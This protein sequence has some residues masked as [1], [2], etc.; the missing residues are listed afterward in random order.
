MPSF[1]AEHPILFEWVVLP[2][3]IFAA[4][5]IDMTLSTLRI[6]SLAQG[7][8]RLAPLIGFFESLIWL[9]VVGQA[10]RH[11]EN[12]LCVVA[13]A[14]GFAAGNLVGLTLERR[15]AFGMRLV[16]VIVREGAD[17]L[18]AALRQADFG[19]TVAAGE[20]LQGP[21]KILFTLVRRRDLERVA[22]MVRA[23]NPRAFL[24]VE[25]VRQAA[26]G[27]FPSFAQPRG[28]SSWM[29]WRRLR[30]SA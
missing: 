4:R 6:V 14:G 30:K 9:V 2:I 19:V 8:R 10:L 27:V 22:E 16:R 12:P 15:L 7:R 20:G 26:Q 23:H 5:T 1:L 11:L 21:V 18:V 24:T 25:D 17:E 28:P 29:P 3:L 13:Y